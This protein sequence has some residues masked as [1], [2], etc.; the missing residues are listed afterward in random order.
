MASQTFVDLKPAKKKLIIQA[1]YHEFSQHPLSQAQVARIVTEANISRG[2]FYVYFTD[3]TDAYYSLFKYVIHDIH[4]GVKQESGSPV[5]QTIRYIRRLQDNPYT[6]LLQMHYRVNESLLA[7]HEPCPPENLLPT[8]ATE[9]VVHDWLIEHLT[10][11]ALVN[12]F[13]YP[14]QVDAI[15]HTLAT[16]ADYL[17]QKPSK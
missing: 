11:E 2:S 9:Q 3:L 10:H 6:A 13:R 4:Q 12:S 14:E 16:S 7:E 1:L 5:E 8:E 17:D 15:V